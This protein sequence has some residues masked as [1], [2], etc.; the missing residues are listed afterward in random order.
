MGKFGPPG[1][2]SPAQQLLPQLF[3][4]ALVLEEKQFMAAR[5]LAQ[6]TN[7]TDNTVNLHLARGIPRAWL[8]HGEHLS[9]DSLPSSVGSVSYTLAWSD[10]H[11][12]RANVELA[13][14]AA[15]ACPLGTISLHLRLPPTLAVTSVS[16]RNQ[17][18]GGY[19]A[20]AEAISFEEKDLRHGR[21]DFI[22]EVSATTIPPVRIGSGSPSSAGRLRTTI[23]V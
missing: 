8:A 3:R 5:R 18:F 15:T 13:V 12:L 19:S 20:A 23:I 2:A 14:G 16:L 4:W 10:S 1:Y 11:H 7:S 6:S 17:P 9:V 21:V 22:V